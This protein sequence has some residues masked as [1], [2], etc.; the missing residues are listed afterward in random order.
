[1]N[2]NNK[3][4]NKKNFIKKKIR[5]NNDSFDRRMNKGLFETNF[6]LKSAKKANPP[7]NDDSFRVITIGGFEE[8][9]RNMLAVENKDEIFVFDVG[10]EF[11]SEDDAPGID[12]TLP[13][14]QYL[15]ENKHKIKAII[16]THAHLDH[17]GGIPF[18]IGE[19]GNPPIYTRNL[20]ALLIKKRMEEFPNAPKINISLVEPGDQIKIGNTSFEFFNVT[21]SIPDC[22]GTSVKTPHGNIIISGDLK[23]AHKDGEPLQREKDTWGYIGSQKNILMISDSTNCENPGWSLQEPIIHETVANYIRNAKSRVIIA[24]FASQFERMMAFV[25]AAENLGKKIILEGRSVKTNMEIA[26]KANYYTPKKDTIIK[27]SDIDKYPSDRIVVIC[28]GGQGEEFA[29]LPRMARNDHKY[30]KLNHRDTVILSSSVIP[31]NEISVRALKDSLLR[32]DVELISYK[33]SDVHSTGHGNAEELAWIIRQVKPHYFVPGYGFHSMLKQHKKIAIEKG[34]MDPSCV[35]VPDNGSVIEISNQDNV[36]VLPIKVQSSPIL[37]D[38]YSVS[39]IKKTVIADRKVLAKEGFIN[40]IVLINIS[41]GR[42]QKSPDILSRGFVYLRES[43]NLLSETRMIIT[44]LAEEE[45]RISRGGKI[46][47]DRLKEKIYEKLEAFFVQRTNKK[48]I[49]IPV[50]LVV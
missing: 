49:I 25:K 31:G 22:V 23:L 21:H 15:K 40:T 4:Y 1:M 28:T 27:V 7:I 19:I 48:P 47:V 29:A 11:T 35:I 34:N 16:I 6:E 24:T 10:F 44:K 36:K 5:R 41:K 45:I 2:D 43:K 17:I 37:V 14:I 46:N 3:N 26:K 33:T 39:D 8:V 30:I 12:Y 20:T 13:N 18:L 38:G 50:V 9:G 32:H 42:L